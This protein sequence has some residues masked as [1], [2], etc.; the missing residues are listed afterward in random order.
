[1]RQ[2][3]E[4]EMKEMLRRTC[5]QQHYDSIERLGNQTILSLSA[6]AHEKI[7]ELADTEALIVKLKTGTGSKLPYFEEL[8]QA[9]FV[10]LTILVYITSLMVVTLRLQIN[11]IGGYLY[12]GSNETKPE[13]SERIREKYLA[14][15]QILMTDGAERLH[16]LIREKV[17]LVLCGRTLKEKLKLQDFEQ[18][19]WAVHSAISDDARNPCKHLAAYTLP[20]NDDSDFLEPEQK[21]YKTLLCETRDLFES[22]EVVAMAG[23]CIKRGFS[24]FVDNISEFFILRS[25]TNNGPSASKA[26]DTFFAANLRADESDVSFVSIPMAKVLPLVSA[27]TRHSGSQKDVPSAWVQQLILMDDL[28]VL[29]ANVYECFSD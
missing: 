28:K 17:E 11:L 24:F 10:K 26:P 9:A 12:K 1:M 19:L 20:A 8:K 21:L 6:T 25:T 4:N 14:F 27:M 22:D 15:C 5:K 7:A 16:E 18:I 2:H 13:V 29:G 3:H 23:S